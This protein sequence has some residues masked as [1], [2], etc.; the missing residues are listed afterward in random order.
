VIAPVSMASAH[1]AFFLDVRHFA[2]RGHFAVFADDATA[3]E[4][5]KAK[6]ADKTHHVTT[7][8][9]PSNFRTGA[10][11]MGLLVITANSEKSCSPGSQNFH[12]F[13]VFCLVDG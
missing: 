13:L 6:K 2:A 8:F 11:G 1:F 9:G 12:R 10:S 4:R 3:G 7:A 5:G